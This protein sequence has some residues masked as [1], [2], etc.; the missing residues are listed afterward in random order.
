TGDLVIELA[1]LDAEKIIGLDISPGMLEIGKQKVK[2]SGL[3]HRIDMQLGDS[4]AL[5]SEE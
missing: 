2:K 1:T 4:E 5:Q 3:D